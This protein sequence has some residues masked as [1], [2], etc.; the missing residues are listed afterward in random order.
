M[1]KKM[2]L[3]KKNIYLYKHDYRCPDLYVPAD[4]DA[5]FLF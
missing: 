2:S 1:E 5:G 4:L 3:S